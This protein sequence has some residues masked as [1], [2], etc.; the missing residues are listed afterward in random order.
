LHDPGSGDGIGESN[1]Q[2]A[3]NRRCVRCLVDSPGVRAARQSK[4]DE[5]R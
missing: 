2:R 4:V 3:D 5:N 1:G